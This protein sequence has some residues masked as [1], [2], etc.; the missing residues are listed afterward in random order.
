MK[1]AKIGPENQVLSFP[2]SIQEVRRDFPNVSFPLPI[3]QESLAG[4]GYVIVKESKRPLSY[5]KTHYDLVSSVQLIGEEWTELWSIESV[6][7]EEVE[8]RVEQKLYSLDY[9]GFWRA[10]TRSAPYG[11]LKSAAS[12]D[13]GANMLATELISVFSDAKVGNLDPESMQ[14]GIV[15]ALGSLESI[16]PALKAEAEALMVEYG[17]DIYLTL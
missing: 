12:V 15:E 10:L 17:L 8:R 3:T 5:D 7:E 4:F 11:A 14:V 1:L 13:L 6:S 9:K 2:C 16:D